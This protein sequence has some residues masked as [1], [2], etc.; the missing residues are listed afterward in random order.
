[1]LQTLSRYLA[2][3]KQS[4]QNPLDSID[5]V[6]LYQRCEHLLSK[7]ELTSRTTVEAWLKSWQ[8]VYV[9]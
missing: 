5:V 6:A 3:N 7:G 4:V 8:L 2:A 1:M 9:Q